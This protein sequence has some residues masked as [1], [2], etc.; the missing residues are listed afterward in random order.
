[1][2][3]VH[4]SNEGWRR[5]RSGDVVAATRT[6]T[7]TSNTTTMMMT[8]VGSKGKW[9]T[10]GWMNVLVVVV[11]YVVL[12]SPTTVEANRVRSTVAPTPSPVPP[13]KQPKTASPTVRPPTTSPAPVVVA[14]HAPSARPSNVPAR[15]SPTKSRAPVV[16]VSTLQSVVVPPLVFEVSKSKMLEDVAVNTAMQMFFTDFFATGTYKTTFRS[17]DLNVSVSQE[18]M[19][20]ATLTI[21]KGVAHYDLNSTT[22]NDPTAAA[23]P[24]V[25]DLSSILM[26]YFSFWGDQNLQQYLADR[27]IP[28]LNVTKVILN[29]TE[30]VNQAAATASTAGIDPVVSSRTNT[31]S[32]SDAF[33][34]FVIAG[35]VVGGL[36]LILAVLLFVRARQTQHQKKAA[37]QGGGLAASNTNATDSSGDNTDDNMNHPTTVIVLDVIDDAETGLHYRHAAEHGLAYRQQRLRTTTTTTEGAPSDPQSVA[38]GR[39]TSG[40]GRVGAAPLP[41]PASQLPADTTRHSNDVEQV[42]HRAA[43]SPIQYLG[44]VQGPHIHIRP[45]PNESA[46]KQRAEDEDKDGDDDDDDDITNDGEYTS[47]GDIISVTE[48]ILYREQDAQG[49][50][51]RNGYE[52]K[53]LAAPTS[54]RKHQGSI[55]TASG[56]AGPTTTMAKQHQQSPAQASFQYDASRLDQVISN[57]KGSQK[58]NME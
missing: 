4:E 16:V 38:V 52:A 42:L 48:S 7:N 46:P 20:Q 14:T 21:A 36:V 15:A 19:G 23:I 55:R 1:M 22:S 34:N 26:T 57:A 35:I 45:C 3:N 41:L 30:V 27:N 25:S 51:F 49:P 40:D 18:Y 31:N 32:T 56:N 6:T 28:V 24:T 11:A 39:G 2:G 58:Y 13:G 44:G 50:L 9:K 37:Q 53:P 33:N 47:D 29:G 8:T 43:N 10:M 17:V 54:V 5:T 12:W